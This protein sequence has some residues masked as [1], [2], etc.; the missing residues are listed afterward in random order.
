MD[1]FLY[2]V[3]N[4]LTHFTSKKEAFLFFFST[5]LGISH[6]SYI[7]II[8]DPNNLMHKILT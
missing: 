3:K 8:L 4:K 6:I 7:L 1:T 2:L 5:I